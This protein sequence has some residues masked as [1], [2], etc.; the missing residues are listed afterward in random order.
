[1]VV[2]NRPVVVLTGLWLHFNGRGTSGYNV[3][4][5]LKHSSG[6]TPAGCPVSLWKRERS[7]NGFV[8]WGSDLVA[9][10]WKTAG[11]KLLQIFVAHASHL[12]VGLLK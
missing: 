3:D 7:C 2:L 6:A 4:F 1:M 9:M 12:K 8:K 5:P 10:G 11:C